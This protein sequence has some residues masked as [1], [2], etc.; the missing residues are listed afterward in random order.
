MVKLLGLE[1]SCDETSAATN[2]NQCTEQNVT[3][4][5]VVHS[6]YGGVVPE[7]ASR[8]HQQNIVPVVEE[9]FKGA[10]FDKNNLD[11]VAYTQGPG[12][13]GALLVGNAF[14]KG[15][16]LSYNIPLIGVNHLHAHNLSHFIEAP[17]PDF[18]FLNLLVSGG[19]TQIVLVKDYLNYEV[20]GQTI[21][22]AA[23][24][25]LD[26][27]GKI[28]GLPYPAG[29]VIDQYAQQGEPQSFQFPEPGI[30]GYDFSFSGLKTSLLYLVRDSLKKNDTFIVDNV[31]NLCAAYQD[32]IMRF[33]ARKLEL[34]AKNNGIKQIGISGGVAANATLR[35]QVYQVASKND[36]QV[37]IPD[38][39]YCTDNA[40]MVN[41]VAHHKYKKGLFED[42]ESIP[43]AR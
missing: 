15:I 38:Q 9:A 2:Q 25:A 41:Q 33:L 7:L 39:A 42:L 29:P 40:A 34:A 18:P 16:S 36:W 21:D 13:I 23:G 8:A 43:F 30:K 26:K 5:Q 32:C 35:E 24:E 22:D 6:D 10:S 37:Y 17:V 11:A 27:G 14:A 19:H 3:K 31:A 1:T 4:T 28:L 20:L 12:L